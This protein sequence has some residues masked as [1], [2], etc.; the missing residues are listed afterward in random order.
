MKKNSDLYLLVEKFPRND[1]AWNLLDAF[2]AVTNG[3]ENPEA[4][5]KAAL[6]EN[7][8]LEPWKALVEA[9][10]RLYAGDTGGCRKAAERIREGSPPASLRP[11]FNA[12]AKDRELR[13]QGNAGNLEKALRGELSRCGPAA[14]DLLKRLVIKPHPLSLIAEQAEE[15]LRQ[16][17][18]EQF[19]LFASRVL[20]SLREQRGGGF[21]ALRYGA[22][23]FSLLNE[24][25]GGGEDFLSAAVKILG[26]ADGLCAFGL[27]L[28]SRDKRGA[29]SAL[30]EALKEGG[31]P[32]K[33]GGERTEGPGKAAGGNFLT[34]ESAGTLREIISLLQSETRKGAG[35]PKSA[36]PLIQRELFTEN[37]L[38]IEQV[39]RI[40]ASFEE[41]E[42]ELPPA[43]RYLGP[44]MWIKAIKES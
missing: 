30:K 35:G 9:I 28:V 21:L 29:L 38:P 12:W 37:K 36:G 14:Q 39:L 11:L 18:E 41:L 44:G 20:C 40:P 1:P 42:R 4:L 33:T 13:E 3:M 6:L 5:R 10:S 8:E 16:G 43:L 24:A 25:G 15:A 17:L 31:A 27:A 23:C 2:D 26:K 34:G 19:A 22:Y 7:R 32:G